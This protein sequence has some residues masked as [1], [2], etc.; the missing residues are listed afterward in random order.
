MPA[1]LTISAATLYA[2]AIVLARVGGALVF[3]PL[4]GLKAAPQAARVGLAAG[5]ALAL[6][7]RWPVVDASSVTVA[8]LAVWTVAEAAMGLAIGLAAAA[9]LEVFVMA[10]Q[11]LGMQAGYSY[12]STIDPN[13]EADS[14]VLLVFAELVAGMTFF[15]LGLDAQVL[16]L[17]ADSLEQVPPGSYGIRTAQPVGPLMAG[18]FS[19]GMRLA[20]PVIALLVMVDVA[21]ALLGR[22]NQQLQLLSLAFPLKMLTALAA[23]AWTAAL[24]PRVLTEYSGTAFSAARRILG[25]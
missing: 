17:F 10:A 13:T 14:G 16:R 21:L 1:R 25:L 18:L 7:S 19:V 15:A 23:L 12:A 22:L 6:F 11:F 3:V 9:A 2:F 4:P 24:F 8:R 5:I 20:F